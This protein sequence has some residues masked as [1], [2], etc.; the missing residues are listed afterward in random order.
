MAM[1]LA[2]VPFTSCQKADVVSNEEQS[3][4]LQAPSGQRIAATVQDVREE[5]AG[6]I[7]R[8]HGTLQGFRLTH[9]EYLPVRKGFAAIISYRLSDGSTGN[10]ATVS[11]TRFATTSP[12]VGTTPETAEVFAAAMETGDD[13]GSRVSFICMR[14]GACD[15]RIQGVVDAESGVVTWKCSC[16]ECLMLLIIT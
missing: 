10:Y 1:I 6:I 4:Q 13:T 11:D 3:L 14:I 7:I 16:I 12:S 2:I 8:K 5:A 15:C 9:I